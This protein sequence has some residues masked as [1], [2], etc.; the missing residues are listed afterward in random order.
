MKEIHIKMI[1]LIIILVIIIGSQAFHENTV[2]EETQSGFP[3][4]KTDLSLPILNGNENINIALP[5]HIS[6]GSEN[7][8]NN[9][10]IDEEE[11][12]GLYQE[13]L[14]GKREI[15]GLSIDELTVP[16][17]ETGRRYP[18]KYAFGDA[19]GDNIPEL[20]VNSARYYYVFSFRD[21]NLF[22]WNDFTGSYCFPLKDGGFIF[23]S[24]GMFKD[25]LYNY[26]TYD[27]DGEEK[28]GICFSWDDFNNNKIHDKED[29]YLFDD[30]A[31]TQDQWN[32][33]T[34]KYLYQDEDNIWRIAN[35]L[36]WTILYEGN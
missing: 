15:E 16:T 2:P 6:N 34:Q 30:E 13:F 27:Y 22:V 3:V 36:E 8:S 10:K 18:T 23:W 24:M 1:S 17:G 28:Y 25:E 7:I 12:M 26:H 33:L 29:E 20:H 31:V 14:D 5:V 4:N 11:V 9:L 19:N 21:G 35:E 32:K